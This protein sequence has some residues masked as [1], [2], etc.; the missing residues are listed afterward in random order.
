MALWPKFWNSIDVLDYF[1]N[2]KEVKIR[3]YGFGKDKEYTIWSRD[4]EFVET[5][6]GLLGGLE[7]LEL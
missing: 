3:E 6:E 1:P 4:Q 7:K 2:M 5:A